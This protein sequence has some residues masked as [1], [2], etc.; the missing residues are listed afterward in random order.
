M[1]TTLQRLQIARNPERLPCV[2]MGERFHTKGGAVLRW[3]KV[4]VVTIWLACTLAARPATAAPFTAEARIPMAAAFG[5]P[6]EI[7]EPVTVILF[8][9]GLAAMAAAATVKR[10]R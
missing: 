2:M 7:P 6:L 10:K 5:V 4:L 3:A 8:G 9:T 1:P